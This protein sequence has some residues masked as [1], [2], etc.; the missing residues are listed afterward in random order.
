MNRRTGAVICIGDEAEQKLLG[1]SPA[2]ASNAFV[3][4]VTVATAIAAAKRQQQQWERQQRNSGSDRLV[5]GPG[6]SNLSSPRTVFE[7]FVRIFSLLTRGI[8]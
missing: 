8:A 4:T 1:E 3:A 7:K 6:V 2:V 5:P